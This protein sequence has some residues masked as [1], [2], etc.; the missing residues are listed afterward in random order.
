MTD[1]TFQCIKPYVVKAFPKDDHVDVGEVLSLEGYLMG[2]H[3]V[4]ALDPVKHPPAYKHLDHE[5]FV[6][7]EDSVMKKH[8]KKKA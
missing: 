6:V 1:R 8:F 3:P 4:L 5:S 2:M 7:F